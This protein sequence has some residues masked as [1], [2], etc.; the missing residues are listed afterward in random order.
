MLV[1]LLTLGCPEQLSGGYLYHRRL[2]ELAGD[3]D[4]EVEF[5][6]V[7]LWPDPFTLAHGDV[8]LV[9]SIAAWLV[10]RTG[11]PPPRPGHAPPRRPGRRRAGLH[12]AGPGPPRR[13]RRPGRAPRRARPDGIARFYAG[14]GV[15][16]LP[17]W[18]EPYGTVYGEA[19]AAGLPV[20][21]WRAGNLPHLVSD[22]VEGG[23]PPWHGRRAAEALRCRDGAT[24]R[25]HSSRP[26][27]S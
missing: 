27:R 19:L 14:A 22:G 12:R 8:L 11:P 18:R 3:H 26:S 6:P 7:R 10:R 25:Q 1:S 9:D 23:G 17:S 20:V 16:V 5:V 24:P 15:F 4:A 2:A 21:G 13:P